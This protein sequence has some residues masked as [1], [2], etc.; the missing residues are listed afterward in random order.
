MNHSRVGR[1]RDTDSVFPPPFGGGVS[2]D[3]TPY[4]AE[5]DRES[6]QRGRGIC[7]AVIGSMTQAMQAEEILAEAAIHAQMVK[8][9]S[10]STHTGCVYGVEVACRQIGNV[11]DVLRRAGIRIRQVL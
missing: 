2:S 10:A 8:V 4:E 6:G 5:N 7:T 11:R 9:S 1:T 3:R